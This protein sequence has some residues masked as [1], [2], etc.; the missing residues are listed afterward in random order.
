MKDT[1]SE[2]RP[3]ITEQHNY[4]AGAF[5][6]G[7]NHGE[8]RIEAVDGKTKALLGK[9]SKDSPALAELLREALDDGVISPDT[10]LLLAMASRHINEDVAHTLWQAAK[11]INEDVAGMLVNASHSINQDVA[12]QLSGTAHTLMTAASRLDINELDRIAGRIELTVGSGRASVGL[13]DLVTRLEKGL[14]SLD[15]LVRDTERL[16]AADRSLG[17]IEEVGN[18]LTGVTARIEATITPPPPKI[19]PDHRARVVA[20][21]WGLGVGAA[22]ILYLVNR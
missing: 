4:G 16:Q 14:G 2:P 10:A 21:F 22:F 9:I 15:Q 13:T 18:V 5:V 12:E 20:F 1:G 6:G 17:R 11:R 7:D 8:I 3:H 19:L